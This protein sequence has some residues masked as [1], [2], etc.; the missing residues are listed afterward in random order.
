[1]PVTLSREEYL[2]LVDRADKSDVIVEHLKL[3]MKV[4]EAGGHYPFVIDESR[5]L[6]LMPQNCFI[7]K[8]WDNTL[9]TVHFKY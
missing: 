5:V 7:E 9:G 3:F 4:L 2:A 6:P 1:M 8:A